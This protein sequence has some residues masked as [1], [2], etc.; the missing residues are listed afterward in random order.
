[1]AVPVGRFRRRLGYS[2]DGP[3]QDYDELQRLM[4]K[5]ISLREPSLGPEVTIRKRET[6]QKSGTGE[7]TR[8]ADLLRGLQVLGTG[9]GSAPISGRTT[10]ADLADRF[11]CTACR[12][13]RCRRQAGFRLQQESQS[14]DELITNRKTPPFV[15]IGRGHFRLESYASENGACP[16]CMRRFTST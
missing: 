12:L 14:R 8:R 13:A 16:Q 7:S 6:E 5:V 1:L 9:S 10:R 15:S 11:I 3:K 4:S 2:A